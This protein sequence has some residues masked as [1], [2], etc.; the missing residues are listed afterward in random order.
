VCRGEEEGGFGPPF[1]FYTYFF[2]SLVFKC[3]YNRIHDPKFINAQSRLGLKRSK[4][5]A[6][7][8][9]EKRLNNSN[10]DFEAMSSRQPKEFLNN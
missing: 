1:G 2:V 6:L 3:Y 4:A 5:G 7:T 8:K 10:N 9:L